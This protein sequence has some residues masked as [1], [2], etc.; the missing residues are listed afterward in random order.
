MER[1]FQTQLWQRLAFACR[2]WARQCKYPSGG[3]EGW[4][5]PGASRSDERLGTECQT[6]QSRMLGRFGGKI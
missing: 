4:H 5:E 2:R 3:E 6:E 1:L